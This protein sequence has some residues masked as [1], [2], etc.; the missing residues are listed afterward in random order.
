MIII[1]RALFIVS[2]VRFKT[3][4][5]PVLDTCADDNDG[6][7]IED[8]RGAICRTSVRFSQPSALHLYSSSSTENEVVRTF[9]TLRHS[10]SMICSTDLDVTI[11][12]RQ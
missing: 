2:P 10:R 8:G 3:S 9:V 4:Q 11:K 5:L 12:P 7:E 6:V 1:G